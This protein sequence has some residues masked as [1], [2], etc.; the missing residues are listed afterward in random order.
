MR[1]KT[2]LIAT[3]IIGAMTFP[4]MHNVMPVAA[5]SAPPAALTATA[6][7]AHGID[8]QAS[9]DFRITDFNPFSLLFGHN[10]MPVFTRSASS[11]TLTT[12]AAVPDY[13]SDGSNPDHRI[14]DIYN[15]YSLLSRG[16][17]GSQIE[18]FY[19][20]KYC[21][22]AWQLV[23]T[24]TVDPGDIGPYQIVHSNTQTCVRV[25]GTGNGAVAVQATCNRQSPDQLWYILRQ[26]PNIV[27]FVNVK[28]DKYLF[29]AGMAPV[30]QYSFAGANDSNIN[31][32]RWIIQPWD[33]CR[34]SSG[35]CI[36]PSICPN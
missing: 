2:F 8:P 7:A 32:Y 5:H 12:A 20:T 36:A 14:V 23:N 3:L 15:N 19:K 25:P 16:G 9:H 18:T 27:Y 29:H 33:G 10:A 6:A 17:V 31:T 24:D 22:E 30:K 28:S 26:A 4:F 34:S 11:A 13:P 1:I 35:K 21:D